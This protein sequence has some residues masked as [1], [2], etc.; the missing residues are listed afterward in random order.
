MRVHN[1]F[2][3]ASFVGYR[4]RTP[5]FMEL[6]YKSSSK[7]WV[8]TGTIYSFFRDLVNLIELYGQDTRYAVAWDTRPTVRRE[9]S[10]DYKSNRRVGM[11]D[12]EEQALLTMRRQFKEISVLLRYAGIPQFMC[13]GYEA[14]DVLATLADMSKGRTVIVVRDK[15]LYQTINRA[16]RLYDFHGIKDYKWF[17]E[18]FGIEPH[19]WID[20]QSLAGDSTDNVKGIT[21]IGIKTAIKLVRAYGDLDSVVEKSNCVSDKDKEVVCT[22]RKLVELKKHLLLDYIEPRKNIPVL[23]ALLINKQMKNIVNRLDA[24]RGLS[25]PL[26]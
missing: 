1:V 14:D 25:S 5:H 18:N 7:K 16:V 15:D 21:G 26:F 19:Q 9:M 8:A 22:A 23:K 24:F 13:P 12:E 17:T 20:V 6:G 10:E 3:D 2:I 4:S 11:T